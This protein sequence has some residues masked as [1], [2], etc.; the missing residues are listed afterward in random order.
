MGN[1]GDDGG[2]G[3]VEAEAWTAREAL[4]RMWSSS[5]SS[6]DG[7]DGID[8]NLKAAEGLIIDQPADDD[9]GVMPQGAGASLPEFVGGEGG[10]GKGAKVGCLSV[11]C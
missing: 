9:G 2:E 7:G 10:D 1:D 11:A 8:G 6:D 4:E 5:P 3:D